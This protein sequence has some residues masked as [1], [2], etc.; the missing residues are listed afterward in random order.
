MH[1]TRGS[2]GTNKKLDELNET[3]R[4]KAWHEKP[5][6]LVVIATVSGLIGGIGAILIV[7]YCF[8]I[9]Q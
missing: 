3:L 5:I 6:G 1:I 8:G 7:Y 2:H 4:N 9:G